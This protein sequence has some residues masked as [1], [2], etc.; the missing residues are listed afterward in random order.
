MFPRQVE[1]ASLTISGVPKEY[2][3]GISRTMAAR[4]VA[5][6]DVLTATA[7]D[8]RKEL[9]DGTITTL[10]LAELYTHQIDLHNHTGLHLNAMISLAP[11]DQ[12]H[13]QAVAL[14]KERAEGKIRGPLHG[15]PVILK[16]NIMTET[17]LGMDTTCGSLALKGVKVKANAPI[18]D[19][20][21]DA[22]MLILGKSNLSVGAI[23]TLHSTGTHYIL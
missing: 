13:N 6:I 16:D 3:G 14:D 12:L 4:K 23:L 19:L 11:Q 8:L 1:G 21:L 15:I 17:S 10:E 9:E 2:H 22:G 7:E 20:L 18:V 5:D